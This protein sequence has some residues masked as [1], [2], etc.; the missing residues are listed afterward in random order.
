MAVP[1]QA[2]TP[3]EQLA[4]AEKSM[5]SGDL[6]TGFRLLRAAAEAGY[7]P[8]QSR[9]GEILD[10]AEEDKEALEWYRKASE[11]GDAAG[12]YGLGMEYATGEGVAKD[13]AQALHWVRRAADK[14]FL[15]AVETLAA[16]YKT[17][18]LGL[19]VDLKLSQEWFAKA[20]ALRAAD[21]RHAP[22]KAAKETK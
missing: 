9:F 13:V 5:S 19:P 22:E 3:A 16:A 18:G 11:Q 15:L 7:A 21:P 20:A 2:A 1:A 14:N 12:E 17:G 6:I 8:A 10:K 4:E